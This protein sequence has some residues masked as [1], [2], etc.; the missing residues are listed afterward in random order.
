MSYRDIQ[1]QK[2]ISVKPAI[3]KIPSNQKGDYGKKKYEFCLPA[4]RADENIFDGFR[5][6]ALQYFKDRK[7][8]WHDGNSSLNLPSTH[9]CCSQSFCVNFWFEFMYRPIELKQL[10]IQLG[11]DVKEMLPFYLDTPLL[12][13]Q[14]KL[15]VAFEWIGE[16]NYLN[17]LTRGRVASHMY[18]SRGAGFTSADF[19]F[20]LLRNDN[21]IQ[22]ILGEW[23]YTENYSNKSIR[24]SKSGKDRMKI[25][26]P[27]LS[28]KSCP[29]KL[30]PSILLDS[31]FFDPFDQMMR[32]QLLAREMEKRREMQADFV[33]TMHISPE[34]NI[35][36]N[37]RITS[38]ALNCYG[39]NIH[40]VWK[41]IVGER[42]FKSIYFDELFR[43]A[44]QLGSSGLN[45]WQYYINTRYV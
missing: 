33:T 44:I 1:K 5:S 15:Y 23:K 45:S 34:Q 37:N 30:D 40:E 4:N 26:K 11:Y 3:W 32:L 35:E 29:I 7:I 16:L 12:D 6:E 43:K 42:Y 41:N 19:A 17:E 39:N 38:T 24:F 9:L 14:K 8:N 31:L 27:F 13:C 25:Y 20:R 18:R 36:L 22:I 2:Q 21:K 28:D 10:L